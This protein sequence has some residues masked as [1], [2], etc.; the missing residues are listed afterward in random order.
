MRNSQ[1]SHQLGGG[2]SSSA[3]A[4]E[5]R[6]RRHLYNNLAKPFTTVVAL[7]TLSQTSRPRPPNFLQAYRKLAA[8]VC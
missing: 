6:R 7:S 1:L 4:L 2:P 3:A 5:A 8:E